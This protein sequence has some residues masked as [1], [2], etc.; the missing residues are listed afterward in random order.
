MCVVD[1]DIRA[2]MQVGHVN[3][4]RMPGMPFLLLQKSTWDFCMR[5]QCA[6]SRRPSARVL[7][8]SLVVSTGKRTNYN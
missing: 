1:R 7:G 2:D 5:G 3:V 6:A 4:E 8:A